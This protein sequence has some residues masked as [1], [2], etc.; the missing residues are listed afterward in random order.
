MTEPTDDE[1]TGVPATDS[2]TPLPLPS[3]TTADALEALE[4]AAV[5]ERVAG[6]AA[7]VLAAFAIRSRRPTDDIAWIEAE[8][9]LVNEAA[10]LI[11]TRQGVTAE[12]VP[13]IARGLSRLGV[14]GSVLEIGEMI[15][16]RKSLAAARLVAAELKRVEK[17]APRLFHLTQPLPS[18]TIEKR[19]EQSFDPD[20]YLLDGA[21]PGLA[22]ARKEVR[23]ARDRLVKR[24]ESLLKASEGGGDG[25]VTVRNGR[26]VIPLRRDSRNRPG[27]IVHDESASGTT[28]FVE[29][30]EAIELG[31]ALRSAEAAEDR[32]VLKVLRELTDLI[33]PERSVIGQAHAMCVRVDEVVARGKYAVAVDGQVPAVGN[34]GSSIVIRRGRHPLLFGDREVVPFDLELSEGER[35]VLISGPNTGG[36]TVLLKAVG[37]ISAMTQCGIIPPVGGGT[38]VPIFTSFF[39]DIGDRQSIAASL[40][41]FSAHVKALRDILEH[42]N[43]AS[44]VLLDEVGSGTDPAEGAALAA[45]ALLSL[46]GRRALTLASTH[47]GTLKQLAAAS[48][49]IVN[50]SLEFDGGSLSPTYRFLKGVPGRSYGLAIARRLGV[51]DEV[52]RAAESQIPDSERHLDAVLAAAEQR[53]REMNAREAALEERVSGLEILAARLTAQAQIQETREAELK[54]REREAEKQARKETKSYLI[55]ARRRV[56]AAIS[57]VQSAADEAKSREARRI[58]EEGINAEARALEEVE[59][60]ERAERPAQQV[61]VGQRVRVG[62]GSVGEVKKMRGDGK[63]EVMV[64]VMRMVVETSTVTPLGPEAA[65][66][67]VAAPQTPTRA[68]TGSR[69]SPPEVDLRGMTGDEAEAAAIQAVDA[70][71]LAERPFLRI[72]HGMGTGVV[73]ERVRR[74]VSSDRRIS[75]FGFAPANQGG[76]GVT[77]VEFTE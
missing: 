8:L 37:L 2:G 45:A 30:A 25:A 33:R 57:T 47:L 20:G 61:T 15:A 56:E 1:D 13:D 48:P 6:N 16:I 27:G 42:A 46:T 38:T 26:Y 12:P 23:S 52:L 44:L 3:E 70:A 29:P 10:A 73:R 5:L 36:K 17:D 41:T 49:G 35:T 24:L 19:L 66:T 69:E 63:I 76:T 59:E 39:T 32:E 40:S 14:E 55:E 7:G 4:F 50:A 34:A 28:L 77:I 21:S 11:R 54:K 68:A 18:R 22:A 58:V 51:P 53:E 72:I 43:D 9:I 75:K 71:F 65:R 60:S 67:P 64:G 62:T 74:V 31:N